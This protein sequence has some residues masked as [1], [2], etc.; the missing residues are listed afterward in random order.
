MHERTQDAM[1]YVRTYGRPDLFITFTC[2]PKW[3]EIQQELEAGQMAHHRHD[4]IARVFR[5]KLLLIMRLFKER[6]IFGEPLCH[7]YTVEWQKRG[8]PHAHILLWLR[9]KIHPNDIDSII[10]A[11]I[12][13][14]DIDPILFDVVRSQM[15]HG[16]CGKYNPKSPC[17]I[18]GKCSK[19]YPKAFLAHTQTGEDGYPKYRRKMPEQGGFKTTVGL[20]RVLDVDNRWI[21]PYNPLLCKNLECTY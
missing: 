20:H 14:K 11:E 7:M 3:T 1:T 5:Q 15:V 10:S 4:I 2:N 16:P 17:M 19:K 21:V 8:L 12:P 6:H 13:D 18:D 9:V